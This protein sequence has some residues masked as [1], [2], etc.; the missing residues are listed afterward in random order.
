MMFILLKGRFYLL[1]RSPIDDD[2][3]FTDSLAAQG[4]FCSAGQ[5]RGDA[6]LLPYIL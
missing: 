4:V 3:A 2:V 5:G 1:P 6:W